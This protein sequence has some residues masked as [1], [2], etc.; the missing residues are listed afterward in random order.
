MFKLTSVDHVDVLACQSSLNG[1]SRD[2][3]CAVGGWQRSLYR[4]RL[5]LSQIL[6]TSGH[7]FS[8]SQQI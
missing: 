5:G 7:Y 1:A 2:V 4:G 3:R 6:L 8:T